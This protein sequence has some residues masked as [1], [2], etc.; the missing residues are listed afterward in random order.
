MNYVSV[1]DIL[2]SKTQPLLLPMEPWYSGVIR[3]PK[4]SES[5]NAGHWQTDTCFS[6]T[7]L[8]RSTRY[9]PLGVCP[10]DLFG[11]LGWV[12]GT[13]RMAARGLYIKIAVRDY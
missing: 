7:R 3:R 8:Q 12:K 10:Y 6:S 11:R 2:D 9:S 5:S 4:S 1:A 13:F